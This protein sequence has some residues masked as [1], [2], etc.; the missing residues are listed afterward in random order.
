MSD[1]NDETV[2]TRR[3][4]LKSSALTAL[5]GLFGPGFIG[6]AQGQ[7]Q[8]PRIQLGQDYE[9]DDENDDLVIR[10][11]NEGDILRYNPANGFTLLQQ[12]QNVPS[13]ATGEL[14]HALQDGSDLSGSRSFDTEEENTTGHVLLVVVQLRVQSSGDGFD[15]ALEVSN[16]SGFSFGSDA[17]DYVKEDADNANARFTLQAIV[18]NGA[19]YEA[20]AF[21]DNDATIE[22]WFERGYF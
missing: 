1:E 5:A 10:H 9:I 2:L 11:E 18:P 21:A 17:V 14:D 20:N 8:E 3:T 13:I 6:V 12:I 19:F 15:V 4:L 22:S 7:T 16:T